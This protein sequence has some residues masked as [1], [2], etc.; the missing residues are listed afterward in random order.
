MTAHAHTATDAPERVSLT[1]YYVDPVNGNDATADATDRATPA[2]T[3]CHVS[4]LLSDGDTLRVLADECCASFLEPLSGRALKRLTIQGGRWVELRE[5][6]WY[7]CQRKQLMRG[8][9]RA[10]KRLL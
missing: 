7:E 10:V 3:L 6:T 4:E 8:L 5:V 9:L 2:A 1:T